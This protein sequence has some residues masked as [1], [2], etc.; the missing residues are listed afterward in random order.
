MFVLCCCRDVCAAGWG[1]QGVR[2]GGVP[3]DVPVEPAGPLHAGY[4]RQA[5]DTGAAVRRPGLH[6]PHKLHRG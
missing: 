4:H 1:V 5:H 3:G 6:D 2:A